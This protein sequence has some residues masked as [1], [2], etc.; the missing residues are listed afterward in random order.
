MNKLILVA[1]L[2]ALAFL[3]NA[4]ASDGTLEKV[5]AGTVT[6]QCNVSDGVRVIEPAKVKDLVEGTWVFTTG[7]AKQCEVIKGGDL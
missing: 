6:L 5:Q 3:A 7:H 4:I 2:G 1:V